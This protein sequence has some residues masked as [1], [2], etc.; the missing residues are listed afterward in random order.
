MDAGYLTKKW[1]F[2][3]LK[4]ENVTGPGTFRIYNANK[5]KTEKKPT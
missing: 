2:I 3:P 5:S 4:Q 1:Q